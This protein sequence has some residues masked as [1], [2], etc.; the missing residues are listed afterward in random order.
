MWPFN[1]IPTKQIKEKYGATLDKE[2]ILHLQKASL[3]ISEGGSGSFVSSQGLLLTNQHV[4][5]QAVFNLST[6]D[7]NLIAEGFYAPSLDQELKCPNLYVDQLVSIEDVTEEVNQ[8]ASAE[9]SVAD[10]EEARKAAMARIKQKAQQQTG[11]QPEIVILYQGARYNLYLYKRYS[12]IRLVMV[13]EEKIA[14]F[15]GDEDNFEYPRYNL[16]IC[17][18]RVYENG[19]PLATDHF[20]QWSSSGPRPS[21]VLFVSGHPG[22]TD[23]LYTSPH[24]EFFKNEELSLYLRL[25]EEKKKRIEAYAQENQEN[26]RIAAQNLSRLSNAYKSFKGIEKGFATTQIIQRKQQYEASLY[27]NPESFLPWVQLKTALKNAKSYYSSYVMLEGMGSGYCK[28]YNWAKVLV[29]SAAERGKP[30]DE[31][32]SEYTDTEVETLKLALFSSAPVY[33]S[34]EKVNLSCSLKLLSDILGEDH[35][36]VKVALSGKSPSE[37]AEELL[38]TTKLADLDYRKHLY[39][40]PQEIESSTDPLI[41]FARALDPYARKVRT[42][43][44]N[45]LESVQNESYNAIAEKVFKRFGESIY[46]DATFTLRLSM[47][48]MKGYHENKVFIEPMTILSGLYRLA[49]QH[50]FKAPFEIPPSWQKKSSLLSKSQVPFNF[51]STNDIVGGNSGS[52][53]VNVKGELVGLIFDGNIQSLTWDYEFDET[54]GRAV[55]VHS[56]GI[57]EALKTVYG[58][59]PL[60]RELFRIER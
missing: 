17:F 7:R 32:L 11:L 10:R 8:A 12:D 18:F 47:G 50:Q 51:V 49:S 59:E 30:N 40:N 24:L 52:P 2:W 25:I 29:R 13:P 55:S 58:A 4:G 20:L 42:Q 5:S 60:I 36:T 23:R 57:L 44:E 38:S 48:V 14:F 1:M 54:Q 31:R 45:E 33:M 27:G 34:L 22:S 21:E 26:G 39:E 6:K 15:G 9:T 41:V 28:L 16:D 43:E 37:R 46:P 3:R 35:P 53:V 19:K 56:Q